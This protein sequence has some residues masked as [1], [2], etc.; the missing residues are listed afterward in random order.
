MEI[1]V[2]LCW[3]VDEIYGLDKDEVCDMKND[4]ICMFNKYGLFI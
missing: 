1:G 4:K 3:D 2:M